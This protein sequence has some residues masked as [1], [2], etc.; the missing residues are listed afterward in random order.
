MDETA[1]IEQSHRD[2]IAKATDVP[3][4]EVTPHTAETP[5]EFVAEK[6]AAMAEKTTEGGDVIKNMAEEGGSFAFGGSTT[7]VG[8]S[9]RVLDIFKKRLAGRL[10]PGQEIEEKE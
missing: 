8:P 10:K 1:K 6:T 4:E 7:E 9:S 5:L 3:V 2:E